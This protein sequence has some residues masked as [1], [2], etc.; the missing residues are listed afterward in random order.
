MVATHTH[1]PL[2]VFALA[3]YSQGAD[4]AGD[5]GSLIARGQTAIPAHLLVGVGLVADPKRNPS[6]EPLV[7]PPV[8]PDAPGV[9]GARAGG[10]G[11]VPVVTFCANGDMVCT[12]VPPAQW[13]ADTALAAYAQYVL[14]DSSHVHESY[15]DYQVAPGQTTTDYLA[16]WLSARLH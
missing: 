5:L 12:Y 14:Y 13:T 15:E 16:A 6:V 9:E 10:F 11:T 4:V 3:G 1:C 7:G 2:T 8:V